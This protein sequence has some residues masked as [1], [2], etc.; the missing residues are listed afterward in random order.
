[1]ISCDGEQS[2]TAARAVLKVGTKRYVVKA[3]SVSKGGVELT[4]EVRLKESSAGFVN[5]LLNIDGVAN[6][7]LVSYNGDY[8]M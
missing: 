6:A 5:S 4:T 1:M 7:T 2:E 8:Y 3:K